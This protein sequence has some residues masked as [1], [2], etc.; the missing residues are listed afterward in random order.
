MNHQHKRCL[1]IGTFQRKVIYEKSYSLSVPYH[2]SCLFSLLSREDPCFYSC[3]NACSR[4]SSSYLTGCGAARTAEITSLDQLG[5][6]GRKI[7]VAGDML[8]YSMLRQDYPEV[9]VLVYGNY[10]MAWEV[11]EGRLDAY[12]YARK[13]IK[14]LLSYLKT[15]DNSTDDLAV[16]RIVNVP[17]RGIGQTSLDKAQMFADEHGMSLYQALASWT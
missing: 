15:I 10:P 14:D 3:S 8:E 2:A 16:R 13:E 17:K 7:G 6:P 5:E 11:A 9:E 12:F 4:G 1:K